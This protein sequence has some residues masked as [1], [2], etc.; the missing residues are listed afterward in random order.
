MSRPEPRGVDRRR[1]LF[2]VFGSFP[3]FWRPRTVTLCGIPFHV[4][5]LRHSA[6][7]YL[8]IHGN[9]ETARQVLMEHMR[10]YPGIAH[11]VVGHERNVTVGGGLLDPNRMFSRM[12]TEKN[13]KLL[14]SGWSDFQVASTLDWLDRGR[15]ALL[16]AL[17]PSTGGLL[18]ALHNNSEG[19]SVQDEVAISD[20][21][22]LADPGDPHAFFL[23]TQ[24]S[25]YTILSKSP[26]N[27]VL[28]NH[29][30]SEDDG[31]LS[32][33]ATRRGIRYINL[34]VG[35]GRF[36][37]QSQMLYWLETNVP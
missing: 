12:G 3:F 37:K 33:L 21:T 7:R 26:F 8:L 5:R 31:S 24:E 32:R 9:E 20:H 22:S 35:L 15:D 14:N 34:E 16:R 28:Q 10:I 4:L 1:F 30:P 29:A 6:R 36:D 23:C 17:L 11:L 2:S 27:V 18:V 13:L 19:Y 25:D